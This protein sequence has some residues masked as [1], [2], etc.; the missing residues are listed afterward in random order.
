MGAFPPLLIKELLLLMKHNIFLILLAFT[1]TL[2]A[3]AVK[4]KDLYGLYYNTTGTN[5]CE[6]TWYRYQDPTN[7]E[8]FT[9]VTIPTTAYY[10]GKYYTVTGIGKDAF[11]RAM[12]L[13]QVNIPATVTSIAKGAFDVCESL[14]EINVDPANP[15]YCSIDGVLFT[16]DTKH[17]HTYSAGRPAE[18]YEIPYGTE[19][20][21]ELSFS[22]CIHLKSVYI[23][24]TVDYVEEHV[25]DYCVKLSDVYVRALTPPGLYENSFYGSRMIKYLH[26]RPGLKSLASIWSVWRDVATTIVD[27]YAIPVSSLS[28]DSESYRVAVRG[29]YWPEVM[30]FPEDN[31]GAELVWSSSDETILRV[32]AS[33]G[34]FVGLKEGIAFVIVAVKDHPEIS[35]KAKVYV[36]NAKDPDPCA[37]PTYAFKDGKI[38]F[39]CATPGATLHYDYSIT[40]PA[41]KGSGNGNSFTLPTFTI[42]ATASASGYSDS[43]TTVSLDFTSG[44]VNGDGVLTITDVTT[45][46]NSLLK[47]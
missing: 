39:N 13:T 31:D 4:F 27:D 6:V 10:D 25:F 29:G 32:N 40:A 43:S 44:D 42:T 35:A 11:L 37:T 45:L 18:A 20:L 26:V 17:L 12:N 34:N 21:Y 3:H 7:Y 16:R 41:L 2:S 8:Y 28:L 23:P 22:D 38:V 36:G 24:V 19:V 1:A 15:G 33:D 14:T 30:M 9:T 46:V 47:K 5:T